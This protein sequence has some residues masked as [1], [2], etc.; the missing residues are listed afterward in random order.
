MRIACIG[1]GPAGLYLAILIKLRDPNTEITIFE[2]NPAG[3]THGWGVVFFNDMVEALRKNDPVTA[4]KILDQ[5]FEWVGQILDMEGSPPLRGL[6]GGFSIGRQQ[7]LDILTARAA[8]LG[9]KI[10]FE[11][12]I[13]DASRLPDADV[14]VAA[15]GASSRLRQLKADRFETQISEGRNRYVWLGTTKIFNNFTFGFAPTKAGWIWFHAYGFS[16]QMSTLI[17]E[18][19]SDTWTGLGFDRLGRDESLACLECIFEHHLAGHRLISKANA[20]KGL[21]WL[22]FRWVKNIKWH[23][24]NIVLVGDSAHTT[25]F[26]IGS[27][28]Q[29]AIQDAISLA[30]NLQA[31]TDVQA[32]LKAYETERQHALLQP[33]KKAHLS[34]QWFESIPRYIQLDPSH[35][36]TLLLSRRSPIV[37]LLPPAIYCQ[38]DRITNKTQVLRKLRSLA[39]TLYYER[40]RT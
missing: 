13:T 28:T 7:L 21:P 18:C 4:D 15:D 24:D 22:T 10:H 23:A 30:T 9:V 33:C 34:A 8:A 14:I 29:L 39:A 31:H 32:A 19:S 20:D 16:Q 27:G 3:V 36:F 1:A 38:L 40:Q 17:A 11:H 5:S 35:F 2:Q 25:H 37:P 6:G 26:S 12:K